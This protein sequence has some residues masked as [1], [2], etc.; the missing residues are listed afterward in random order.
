MTLQLINN[1]QHK[2]KKHCQNTFLLDS[3][4]M[5]VISLT[6]YKSSWRGQLLGL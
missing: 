5:K 2:Y 3:G 6:H 1:I 4:F